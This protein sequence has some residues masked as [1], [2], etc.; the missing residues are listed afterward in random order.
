MIILS[1]YLLVSLITFT[2]VS[3]LKQEAA[4]KPFSRGMS[5]I[6]YTK[7]HVHGFSYRA[8]RWCTWKTGEEKSNAEEVVEDKGRWAEPVLHSSC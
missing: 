3:K 1:F 5:S 8:T 4:I 7:K 6:T 2:S